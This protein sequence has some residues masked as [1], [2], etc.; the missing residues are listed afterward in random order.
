MEYGIMNKKRLL[1]QKMSIMA[2]LLTVLILLIDCE[3]E[4]D[5]NFLGSAIVESTTITPSTVVGG[6]LVFMGVEE[7]DIVKAGQMIA[8]V[9][10]IPVY[11]KFQ[12]IEAAEFQL[13]EERTSFFSEQASLKENIKGVKR[14]L[15]RISGLVTKG[16]VPAQKKD[17]LET[18]HNSLNHKL[19]STTH[20]IKAL[21]GRT[22]NL[23]SKKEQL[24]YQLKSCKIHSPF[25]GMVLTV[26]KRRGEI[27]GPGSPVVEIG[28]Y[29]TMKVDFFIPQ[30]TLSRITIGMP[31]NIRC[32]TD[33]DEPILLKGGI[34]WI[35]SEAEFSPENIQTRESRNGLVFRIRALVPNPDGVLKRG[36]PVEVWRVEG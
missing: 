3:K 5:K 6:E 19:T 2:A 23:A 34:S 27:I 35:N 30:T 20:K 32:D 28:R 7:G 11:L 15:D 33:S 4:K 10:T 29:D 16:A 25:N 22:K 36:L 8:L 21:N 9:D 14:E 1:Y 18:E 12:E 24:I 26:Y 31:V 13:R 17:Q